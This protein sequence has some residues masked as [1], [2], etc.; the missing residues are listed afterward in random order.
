MWQ[1]NVNQATRDY[2]ERYVTKKKE[3][4]RIAL[5]EEKASREEEAAPGVEVV[6]DPKKTTNGVD[7]KKDESTPEEDA[8]KFGLV[9]EADKEVD[10]QA[11]QKLNALLAERY[12]DRTLQLWLPFMLLSYQGLCLSNLSLP[13]KVSCLLQGKVETFTTTATVAYWFR[14]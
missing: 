3:R 5:E 7:A 10:D 9:T 4:E 14:G 8:K 13:L 2:L 12:T 11:M 6:P 1:L